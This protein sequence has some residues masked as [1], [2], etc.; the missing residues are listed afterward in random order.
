MATMNISLPDAMKQWVEAQV[1][2]GRYANSS[3]VVRD[4]V[5]REQER[6]R[7]QADFDRVVGEAL[8]SPRHS[9]GKDE[10]LDIVMKRAEAA[11]AGREKR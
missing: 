7:Q 9:Y 3:D 4:L 10:L 1:E 8:D 5:R 2:T 6:A 11:I